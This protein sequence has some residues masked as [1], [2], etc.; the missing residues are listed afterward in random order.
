MNNEN[1]YNNKLKGFFCLFF[2][3]YFKSNNNRVAEIVEVFIPAFKY[4]IN[5][6]DLR[7]NIKDAANY[8]YF[9]ICDSVELP[10][11]IMNLIL[12]E[13]FKNINNYII[14]LKWVTVLIE[15]NIKLK[16]IDINDNDFYDSESAVSN[17][18]KIKNRI[19][20]LIVRFENYLKLA[21]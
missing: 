8:V 3:H 10:Q 7:A 2:E 20:E 14:I 6:K 19:T 9:V 4:M 12:E 15:F 13:I 18:V 16:N 11:L 1:S 17:I 5:N 21:F